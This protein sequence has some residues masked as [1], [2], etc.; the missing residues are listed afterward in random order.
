MIRFNKEKILIKAEID[1]M[2]NRNSNKNR[3]L[4]GLAANI[5]VFGF[6]FFYSI[7]I[8]NKLGLEFQNYSLM[9][10]SL[11]SFIMILISNISLTNDSIFGPKEVNILFPMPLSELEII[12]PKILTIYLSSLAMSF[13]ILSYPIIYYAYLAGGFSF[14]LFSILILLAFP[15]IPSGLSIILTILFGKIFQNKMIRN[16]FLLFFGIFVAIFYLG[17][18]TMEDIFLKVIKGLFEVLLKFPS[19]KFYT[20][21]IFMGSYFRGLIFIIF[22]LIIFFGAA[23][24]LAKNY[25]KI[26]YRNN[27]KTRH[28]DRDKDTFH[29]TS[30]NLALFRKEF[31]L[32]NSYPIYVSNTIISV[33][34]MIILGLGPLFIPF[35]TLNKLTNFNAKDFLSTY[36]IQLICG[37]SA[38]SQT[39]YCCLSVEGKN[40][41]LMQS[42]PLKVLDI[43]RGKILLGMSLITGPILLFAFTFSLKFSLNFIETILLICCGL[44]YGLFANLLGLIYDFYTLDLDWISPNE[45]IKQRFTMLLIQIIIIF[46]VGFSFLISNIMLPNSRMISWSLIFILSFVIDLLLLNDL[47]TKDLRL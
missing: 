20:D 24:F 1:R 42:L 47:R 34:F 38:L 6:F 11:F 41:Y 29:I 5:F 10:F 2:L 17:L 7:S 8:T 25:F 45:V 13:A 40:Y 16:I 27:L 19:I 44:S 4:S 31:A 36:L 33:I 3:L 9:G 37:L 15:L 32:Y 18:Y 12:L 35:E 43:F 30:K 21:A 26:Y 14:G 22:S 23:I 28:R 39:T 46:M